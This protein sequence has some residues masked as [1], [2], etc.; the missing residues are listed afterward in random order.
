MEMPVKSGDA[1]PLI[2]RITAFC[3]EA[4]RFIG[5]QRAILVRIAVGESDQ[6][7]HEPG[8]HVGSA[9]VVGL[10]VFLR[11]RRRDG[12]QLRRNEKAEDGVLMEEENLVSQS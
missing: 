5:A 1:G 10:F 6:E 8:R 2:G 7:L 11:K 3:P 12:K 4:A 9:G